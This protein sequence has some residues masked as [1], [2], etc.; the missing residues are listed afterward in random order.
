MPQLQ[1]ELHHETSHG[2]ATHAH[3]TQMQLELTQLRAKVQVLQTRNSTLDTQLQKNQ[4]ELRSCKKE[5]ER[6]ATT[7]Q[8][9]TDKLRK[10]EQELTECKLIHAQDVLTWKTRMA[11]TLQR[12]EIEKRKVDDKFKKDTEFRLGELR[13]VVAKESKRRRDAEARITTLEQQLQDH[14]RQLEAQQS[15]MHRSAKESKSIELLL[16]RAHQTEARLKS[17]LAGV[18]ARLVLADEQRR[19]HSAAWHYATCR[20][21]LLWRQKRNQFPLELLDQSDEQDLHD[22]PESTK[23]GIE[24]RICSLCE[25]MKSQST[26][27]A[28]RLAVLEAELEKARADIN[29]LRAVHSR[30]LQA[31]VEAFRRL[32]PQPSIRS[33]AT[34]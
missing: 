5:S 33:A 21:E 13:A 9:H 11:S 16:R 17:Q 19:G 15:E 3:A 24:V 7:A 28:E 22:G 26:L 20:C 1:A 6:R 14:Q 31:Q 4:T 18:K 34:A 29:R 12:I 23:S 8:Q 32:I 10:V 25:E 30:E 2:D 27:Q